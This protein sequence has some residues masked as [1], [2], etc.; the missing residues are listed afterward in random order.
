MK[1]INSWNDLW[2]R[3]FFGWMCVFVSNARNQ[4]TI[5][6]SSHQ[7]TMTYS[8]RNSFTTF[9]LCL[10][11]EWRNQG[12][13]VWIHAQWVSGRHPGRAGRAQVRPGR[14]LSWAPLWSVCCV[15]GAGTLSCRCISM[16][17]L[18][19]RQQKPPLGSTRLRNS[20][21]SVLPLMALRFTCW[22]FGLKSIA[23]G[24]FL[25]YSLFLIISLWFIQASRLKTSEPFLSFFPV[26]K[27]FVYSP[28][29]ISLSLCPFYL[30]L[31]SFF[32]LCLDSWRSLLIFLSRLIKRSLTSPHL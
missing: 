27:N 14:T 12:A 22:A 24:G 11:W 15:P 29:V 1:N 31:M 17:Q 25:Q 7:N 9:C 13:S 16:W 21:P 6:P 28:F 4:S 20:L 10:G 3:L 23:P 19:D 8:K 18:S 30:S 32:L 5:M 2:S 26:A